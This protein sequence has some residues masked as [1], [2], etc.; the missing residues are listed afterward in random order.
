[1]GVGLGFGVALDL[2]G[3]VAGVV[4]GF[5]VVFAGCVLGCVGVVPLAGLPLGLGPDA[6][7][8]PAAGVPPGVEAGSVVIGVGS[9]GNG[10]ARMPAI[11]SL[12]P[13]SV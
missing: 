9:G 7:E 2:A 8:P 3:S 10:F 11:I 4:L 6:F 5:V 13:V 1:M 12:S